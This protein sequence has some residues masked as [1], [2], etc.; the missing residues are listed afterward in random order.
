MG[1]AYWEDLQQNPERE[2][3]LGYWHGRKG[4]WV[5]NTFYVVPFLLTPVIGVDRFH[6]VVPAGLW[7][8]MWRLP[9]RWLQ[10][11][12]CAICEDC[13]LIYKKNTQ[14]TSLSCQRA[15]LLKEKNHSSVYVA[16]AICPWSNNYEHI[17]II[18]CLWLLKFVSHETYWEMIYSHRI[19][20]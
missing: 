3:R 13:L 8:R 1:R 11:H 6:C 9:K 5:L 20:N 18:F 12:K 19:T 14:P 4:L 7:M 2:V 10:F 15:S 16:A 17:S